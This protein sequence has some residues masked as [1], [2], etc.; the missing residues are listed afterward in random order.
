MN[1]RRT[2]LGVALCGSLSMFAM[3][4]VASADSGDNT[5]S[6]PNAQVQREEGLPTQAGTSRTATGDRDADMGGWASG[7]AARNH[8][9]ISRRAYMDEMGR[10]WDA[11]DRAGAGLTPAEV[12]RLTGHADSSAPPP[13]TGSSVQPGN[14]GPGNS[15]G[16]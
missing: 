15:K 14:M 9:R 11:A 8:G 16:K 12:S 10:R 3:A 1:T 5:N 7:Y 2:A 13:L 6:K 4:P